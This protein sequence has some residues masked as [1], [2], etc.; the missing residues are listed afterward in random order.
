M[1]L[2]NIANVFTRETG[3]PLVYPQIL[4][5]VVSYLESEFLVD[6]WANKS[7]IPPRMFD[8]MR[9][10]AQDP[11]ASND[12]M[13]VLLHIIAKETGLSRTDVSATL[14]EKFENIDEDVVQLFTDAISEI[15]KD[16]KSGE[17]TPEKALSLAQG[18]AH[19]D[20]SAN[21]I[22]NYYFP[23][24]E[25]Y[26]SKVLGGDVDDLHE[27][28]MNEF[29]IAPGSSLAQAVASGSMD[30]G[31]TAVFVGTGSPDQDRS[32]YKLI[33]PA[34]VLNDIII[35]VFQDP[36]AYYVK[37]NQVLPTA[38]SPIL[39]NLLNAI[40]RK[41]NNPEQRTGVMRGV[42]EWPR[43]INDAA[44][45]RAADAHDFFGSFA[46]FLE[47]Y[48]SEAAINIGLSNQKDADKERALDIQKDFKKHVV[49]EL[50]DS[51][52]AELNEAAIR[53]LNKLNE[54]LDVDSQ[55]SR[56]FSAAEKGGATMRT[57]KST[58]LNPFAEYDKGGTWQ[59]SDDKRTLFRKKRAKVDID[60]AVR[61]GG[62]WEYNV[63]DEILCDLDNMEYTRGTIQAC[64]PELHYEILTSAGRRIAID[65]SSIIDSLDLF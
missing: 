35:N 43:T 53:A 39:D 41:V 37:T 49:T 44:V 50:S 42:D 22:E 60:A 26:F 33:I 11:S 58:H 62:A 36:G 13:G 32:K 29:G 54:L 1:K 4:S 31:I 30:S 10:R 18:Y 3:S 27:T 51:A 9:T 6:G 34:T 23:T 46:R 28:I 59:L 65:E 15:S 48:N 57:V 38:D 19:I 63:G 52:A 16:Y 24:L 12:R 47:G 7:T 5:E 21:A 25:D 55:N 17:I 64:L 56:N 61:R 2:K 14:A 45:L 8:A 40:R 20:Q